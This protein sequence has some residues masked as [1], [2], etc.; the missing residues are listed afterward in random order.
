MGFS[1]A[2]EGYRWTPLAAAGAALAL[3]G[4]IGAL[5]RPRSVIAPPDA[6]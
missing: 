3:G 5:S 4:M 1:T 6:A 2:L